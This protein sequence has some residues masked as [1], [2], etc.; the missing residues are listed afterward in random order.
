MP[1]AVRPRR[2]RAAAAMNAV[3]AAMSGAVRFEANKKPAGIQRV[4]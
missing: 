3:F 4:S 1:D 2:T